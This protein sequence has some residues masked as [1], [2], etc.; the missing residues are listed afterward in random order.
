MKRRFYL[1]LSLIL[2]LFLLGFSY[3]QA[4]SESLAKANP[5]QGEV[6]FSFPSSPASNQNPLQITNQPLA[7]QACSTPVTQNIR[8]KD[9]D[10]D[11]CY[12]RTFSHSGTN[13]TVHVY[14]TEQDTTANLNR[15]DASDPP[16]RCEHKISNNDDANGD[17]VNAVA[18]GVEAESAVRFYHDRNLPFLW[19]G[20]TLTV[21]IAEDPRGGGTPTCNSIMV[22][23]EWVD[24]NDILNKRLL[25]FHEVQH[26]IQCHYQ[27]TPGWDGFYGEGIARAI[28]D[29]IENDLDLDTGHL[30]IPEVAGILSSNATRVTD[31][32]TYSY[33]TVLWWTWLMDRYSTGSETDP[34]SGWQSIRNFYLGVPGAST[35]LAS[36]KT[37]LSNQGSSFRK[38]FTDYTLALFAYRFTN[39]D[40]RVDFRDAE[41]NSATSGLSG[42]TVITGGPAYSTSSASLAPRS[43]RYWEF[44]PASQCQ[45]VAFSF[46]GGTKSYSFSVMTVDTGGSL[47]K[48]WTSYSS[49]WARTV[50]TSGLSRVVGVVSAIDDSGNVTVGRGCVTPSINIKNPTSAQF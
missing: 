33:P 8:G 16:G 9:V 39:S 7:P 10:F 35:T 13:Y 44:N 25:A 49:S 23:D 3:P 26:L 6:G 17:N 5:L 20:T 48:R 40:D 18:M 34:I 30:F 37:Y 36:L 32:T 27:P 45:F 31:L 42:H 12:E 28:E 4:V 47:Q 38:D 21:Y 2:L 15:C 14:Y 43:S 22:D 50:R 24:N 29:R 1:I 41:I 46:S 19:S 11:Q